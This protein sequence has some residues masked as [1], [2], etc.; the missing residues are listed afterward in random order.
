MSCSTNEEKIT[1]TYKKLDEIND[2]ARI[3]NI[4]NSLYVLSKNTKDSILYKK[5]QDEFKKLVDNEDYNLTYLKNY[6]DTL[7]ADFE[8][9]KLLPS[10]FE[11]QVSLL[12][13]IIAK[14]H[15]KTLFSSIVQVEE[16]LYE[17]LR[18]KDFIYI[19]GADRFLSKII[20]FRSEVLLKDSFEAAAFILVYNEDFKKWSSYADL[21]YLGQDTIFIRSYKTEL[22]TKSSTLDINFKPSKRGKYLLKGSTQIFADN[23]Y[24]DL[25]F[26]TVFTVK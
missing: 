3:K 18:R 1:N 25:P 26:E 13:D 20:P 11:E 9:K 15:Y 19:D 12:K 5:R 4:N 21:F 23:R 8:N 7:E 24:V 17:H 2:L 16:L 10:Q 6:I 22:G 14:S